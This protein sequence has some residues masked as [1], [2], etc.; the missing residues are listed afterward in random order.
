M[1]TGEYSR[2]WKLR[3]PE[4]VPLVLAVLA[5][6]AH[7]GHTLDLRQAVDTPALLRA[8]IRRAVLE[9]ALARRVVLAARTPH[10]ARLV[11]AGIQLLK[12]RERRIV[13]DRQVAHQL[14]H[15]ASRRAVAHGSK[16]IAD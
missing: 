10:A 9:G 14:R 15:R 13:H 3:Q 5:A 6:L 16:A 7:I 2:F 12:R 4:H 8:R 1:S 11:D